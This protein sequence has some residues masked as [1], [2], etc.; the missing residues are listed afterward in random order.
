[1]EKLFNGINWYKCF[2]KA[3][4]KKSRSKRKHAA[5]K[6]ILSS[7]LKAGGFIWG[8]HS[9]EINL[10]RAA[11]KARGWKRLSER[12]S[13]QGMKK[14]MIVSDEIYDPLFHSQ[15]YKRKKEE[16]LGMLGE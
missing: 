1:M 15:L 13:H 12:K 8:M 10:R 4:H 7:A 5:K 6:E 11:V 2:F 16:E 3:A 14:L 9:K